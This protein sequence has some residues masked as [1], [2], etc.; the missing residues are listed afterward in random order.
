MLL[1]TAAWNGRR[2]TTRGL[3]GYAV[4]VRLPDSIGRQCGWLYDVSSGIVA[5]PSV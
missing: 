5:L 4:R 3:S 1:S 2:R